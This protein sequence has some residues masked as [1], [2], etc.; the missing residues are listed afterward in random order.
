M[1]KEKTA[2]DQVLWMSI[3]ARLWV[4]QSEVMVT[5]MGIK[6][7]ACGILVQNKDS[8][9]I[10]QIAGLKKFFEEINMIH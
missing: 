3:Q 8:N 10:Q 4:P 1:S 2:W 6:A 9:W 7:M 5:I